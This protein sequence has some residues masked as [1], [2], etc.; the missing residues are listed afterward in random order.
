MVKVTFTLD[1]DTVER[2]GR[3]AA[4]LRKPKSHVVREAVRE[5]ADRVGK[6]SPEERRRMLALF[7]RVVPAIPSRPLSEVLKELAEIRASRHRA[8]RR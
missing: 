1:D 5:F 8:W 3:T 4:R 2:I 7:D 6:L